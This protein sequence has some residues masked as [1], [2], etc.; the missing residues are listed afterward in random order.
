MTEKIK[1]QKPETKAH[2]SR[3]KRFFRNALLIG[4]LALT[5]TALSHGAHAAEKPQQPKTS[6]S[7]KFSGGA[8]HKGKDPFVGVG[9]S[10]GLQYKYLLVDTS[11]S[12]IFPNF[13]DA[14]LDSAEL[15]MTFR[16][17]K[18]FA[19]TPFVYRSM[20][21]G[22]VA[23]CLGTAFH[24]PQFNLHA[25]LSYRDKDMVPLAVSWTPNI[26][27]RLKLMF[28]MIFQTRHIIDSIPGPFIGGEIGASLTLWERV[29]LFWKVFMM[30]ARNKEGKISVGAA[31]TQAGLEI[32]Y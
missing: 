12:I 5:G 31:N 19:I 23:W 20:Y 2:C 21:Y 4:G 27:E 1:H 30:T 18:Y 25:A 32:G 13:K 9:L 11:T 7:V 24:I 16:V 28:K 15:N 14:K 29:S 17:N 8:Y 6:L 10:A 26:G 22:D 3:T